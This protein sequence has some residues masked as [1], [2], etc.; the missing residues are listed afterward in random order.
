MCTISLC[1]YACACGGSLCAF[2]FFFKSSDCTQSQSVCRTRAACPNLNRPASHAPPA[3]PSL[4]KFDWV[5]H[6]HSSSNRA[7]DLKVPTTRVLN[8]VC[9]AAKE[10]ERERAAGRQETVLSAISISWQLN[11]LFTYIVPLS[12]GC[13]RFESQTCA[14]IASV[15]F[16]IEQI[17][18]TI[19][20]TMCRAQDA[21]LQLRSSSE[22]VTTPTPAS[23]LQ[24]VCQTIQLFRLNPGQTNRLN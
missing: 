7:N 23:M 18:Q 13:F 6:S 5:A 15:T 2:P 1:Q 16:W 14:I 11:L 8:W 17:R 9:Y 10:G 22:E 4:A 12:Y 20:R 3:S 19:W 24:F 21:L